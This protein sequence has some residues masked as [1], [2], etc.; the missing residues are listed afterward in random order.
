MVLSRGLL[1]YLCALCQQCVTIHKEFVPCSKYCRVTNVNTERGREAS[2]VGSWRRIAVSNF[3][4]SYYRVWQCMYSILSENRGLRKLFKFTSRP[5]SS[6]QSSIIGNLYQSTYEIV[7][8]R[9]C[10]C[11]MRKW[12]I[13]TPLINVQINTGGELI[14]ILT[15]IYSFS[16]CMC[17][18]VV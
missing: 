8:Y 9:S 4:I 13:T 11:L 14:F 2:N 3:T 6:D 10:Q 17:V 15:N 1:Q 18:Y 5:L 12:C 16:M 7:G